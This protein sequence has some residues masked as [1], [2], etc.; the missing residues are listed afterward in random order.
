M[1][2]DRIKNSLT[3]DLRDYFLETTAHG[4]RYLVV[5]RDFGEILAW[6]VVI[7]TGFVC[8]GLIIKENTLD[9][10]NFP[11]NLGYNT[12]HIF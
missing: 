6:V 5:G 8:S 3:Q 4:F 12:Q 10:E 11:G 7:L 1:A 2:K 9:W